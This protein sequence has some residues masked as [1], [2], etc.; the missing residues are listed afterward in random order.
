MQKVNKLEDRLIEFILSEE[1][2][3]KKKKKKG[4]EE[5]Q[6]QKSLRH[7]QTDLLDRNKGS[8]M[9]VAGVSE[10]KKRPTKRRI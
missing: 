9:C 8:S 5:K 6:K 1:E 10:G 3:K 7:T 4:Q 2:T